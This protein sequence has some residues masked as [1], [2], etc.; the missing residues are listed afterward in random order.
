MFDNVQHFLDTSNRY[1]PTTGNIMARK[2]LAIQM[3]DKKL[4]E[5]KQKCMDD[6]TEHQVFI[7]DVVIPAYMEDRITIEPTPEQIERF[8]KQQELF[9]S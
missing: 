5:F 8:N 3:D 1:Q 6:G 7:R 4:D 9:K 2:M